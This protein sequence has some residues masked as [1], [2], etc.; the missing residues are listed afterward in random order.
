MEEGKVEII[1]DVP[2][3][4][5]I[6]PPHLRDNGGPCETEGAEYPIE[7]AID[8]TVKCPFTLCSQ[9]FVVISTALI[10]GSK[11]VE[12]FVSSKRNSLIPKWRRVN[13]EFKAEVELVK[14]PPSPK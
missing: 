12:Q 13:I 2:Y 7:A 1:S 10:K 8:A 9:E 5:F 11:V 6:I 14:R 4:Y 3:A